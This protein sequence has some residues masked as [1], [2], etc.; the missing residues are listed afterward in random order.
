PPVYF[1]EDEPPLLLS[2][3]WSAAATPFPPQ[4]CGYLYYHPPPPRAPLGGSLR[5]R[6]SSDDALGSD[7][8]LP[9]GLP[10]EIVLPR[11]V[12]YKHCVGAL[13]RLLEDGL[14]TT[15]TVE[16]CRNVFAGRPLIP[17]QLIF[18]LEQPFALS[19]EQS[20]LQLT[21]VGHDKLGSFVKEKLFGDPGPRY[22]FKGAVLAR[23]EL[24][25]DRVYFFM[26]IVKIVSPVVCC[27]DGYDGRV[28]APQEG[29]FL[30]YRIGGVTRPWA[31]RIA[32]R[33]SAASALRLLVDP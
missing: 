32:S 13:Q 5:L 23:F 19:M 12:R 31:L 1:Y 15:T 27:E 11:I 22:P 33:S 21:I 4:A 9:N 28:V 30:S 29:G 17:R 14:L 10:W 8:M 3:H 6:V 20:K 2:Y 24:S 7:L 18:H 16:H 26:R 25:P